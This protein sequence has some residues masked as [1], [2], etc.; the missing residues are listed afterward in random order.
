MYLG[1]KNILQLT[2]KLQKLSKKRRAELA[3]TV[4][5]RLRSEIGTQTTELQHINPYELLVA[6]ILSAQCTDERVN[7]VTPALFEKFPTVMEM[8]TASADDIF[9][10]IRSISFPNNKAKNLAKM[11]RQVVKNFDGRIP[12]TV[13]ELESLAGA[14]HKTA[15]VVAGVAFGEPTLAVD[16]HVFRVANRI[17]LTR[18]ARTPQAV[19][20]Q[21]KSLAPPEEWTDIHH[22]LI[23]HGRYH[24][25]ARSPGCDT[26]VINNVCDYARRLTR[27]PKD[28]SGLDASRGR[29]FCATR[30]HYFDEADSVS[31]RYGTDQISCPRCGSMNI[32]RSSSGRTTR[33]IKDY[34]V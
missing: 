9:P 33:R 19:E 28:R 22:L 29:F 18:H 7:L 5:D 12:R 27:L 10:F 20:S 31:D 32:F 25:T 16:T 23:F 21:L 24:C 1:V 2:V 17:G 34:R 26:C 4:F 3:A 15:Q 30:G 11:A 13:K 14:G 8:S 6:T